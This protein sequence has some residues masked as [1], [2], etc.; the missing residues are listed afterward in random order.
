[1]HASTTEEKAN[2]TLKLLKECW[3]KVIDTEISEEELDVLKIKYRGQIAHSL[4]S[5]SQ[6][7][8]HKAHLLGIGLTNYHDKEI[9]IRLK[10]ISS[11]EIKDAANIYLMNPSLSVCSNKNIL[12]KISKNWRNY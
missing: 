9:L 8:E 10:N 12:Q 11:K 1:M 3:Q 6:K 5:I 4:Q 7:A 2:L